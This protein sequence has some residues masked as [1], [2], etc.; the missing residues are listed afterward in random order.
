MNA[1]VV[2]F[3]LAS[4]TPIYSAP[5]T[6]AEALTVFRAGAQ[7]GTSMPSIVMETHP[8]WKDALAASC[9][10]NPSERACRI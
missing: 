2:W 4:S 6:E 8:A 5:L 7:E 9:K 3:I 1:I 10:Q